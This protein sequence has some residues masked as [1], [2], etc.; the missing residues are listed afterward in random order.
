VSYARKRLVNTTGQR[1]M[2]ENLVIPLVATTAT[3]AITATVATTAMDPTTAT[4]APTTTTTIPTKKTVHFNKD[5]LV[6]LFH[7]TMITHIK[8]QDPDSYVHTLII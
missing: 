1:R 5:W 3:E 2:E 7:I 8:L 6:H 4:E